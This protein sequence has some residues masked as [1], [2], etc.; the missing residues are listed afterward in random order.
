MVKGRYCLFVYFSLFIL[1]LF[2]NTFLY[3]KEAS[4]LLI[5][6]GQ[7]YQTIQIV[8][9]LYI[10]QKTAQLSQIKVASHSK[11]KAKKTKT[12]PLTH[13][14]IMLRSLRGVINSSLPLWVKEEIIQDEGYKKISEIPDKKWD[15]LID[16]ISVDLDALHL[17]NKPKKSLAS[18][19]STNSTCLWGWNEQSKK[20]TKSIS[21]SQNKSHENTEYRSS[22]SIHFTGK[23]FIKA[24][25]NYKLKSLCSVPYKARF[26]DS[27]I[28][29][30]LKADLSFETDAPASERYENE[31]ELYKKSMNLWVYKKEWQASLYHFS[32]K[33]SSDIDY[34]V[35]LL[36]NKGMDVDRVK[37][38]LVGK[39]KIIWSCTSKGCKEHSNKTSFNINPDSDEQN[40]SG[41]KIVVIPRIDLNF[42][43]DVKMFSY[44][45]AKGKIGIVAELP[46]TIA[47]YNA[48][49]CSIDSSNA[50]KESESESENE[51][52]DEDTSDSESTNDFEDPI[53][54]RFL[55]VTLQLYAYLKVKL[56]SKE[57]F[58]EIDLGLG[59]WSK[60]RI[61]IDQSWD[62]KFTLYKK[63]LF[64]KSFVH[65]SIMEPVLITDETIAQDS[66]VEIGR[67]LCYPFGAE[68]TY[69]IDWGDGS[70]H[71]IGPAGSVAHSWGNAGDYIIKAKL[72]TDEAKRKF[73]PHWKSKNITVTP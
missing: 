65:S 61:N 22:S 30:S 26:K 45:I 14:V 73:K 11:L 32:L 59:D 41:G 62:K 17:L 71:Y 25:I 34:G 4:F 51:N 9:P 42:S 57:W 64:F 23:G 2:L 10:A 31:V 28:E 40:G 39:L 48:T 18:L 50:Y 66:V 72:L 70:E 13:Q 12:S 47:A 46:I 21:Y 69:E 37:T 35:N 3:A 43:A 60:K 55:D 68:I 52:E 33:L 44:N 63:N 1:T 6:E 49:S 24:T 16:V 54:T 7:G 5:D 29:L 19:Q 58:L 20:I 15:Q 56:F 27:K 8:N 67:H 36:A 53:K 38:Q